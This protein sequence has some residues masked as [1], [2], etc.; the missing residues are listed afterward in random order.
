MRATVAVRHPRDAARPS[1]ATATP[2]LSPAALPS[3][4]LVSILLSGGDA[5]SGQTRERGRHFVTPPIA[6]C[7]H[8]IH[9]V[10]GTKLYVAP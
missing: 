4:S 9:L 5:L 10:N 2:S 6:E 1:Q 3:C 8:F 7:Q